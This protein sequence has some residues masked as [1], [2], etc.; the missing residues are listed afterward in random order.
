[1]ERSNRAA[2]W[3][4]W[5]AWF[6]RSWTTIWSSTHPGSRGRYGLPPTRVL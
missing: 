3:A 5:A 1:V 6:L 4:L 2:I